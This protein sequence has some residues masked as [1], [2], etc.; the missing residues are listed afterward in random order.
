MND[1]R[2]AAATVAAALTASSTNN[3]PRYTL[4]RRGVPRAA[5]KNSARPDCWLQRH[6]APVRM[7]HDTAGTEPAAER[8]LDAWAQRCHPRAHANDS[9]QHVDT[10]RTA[11]A[12]TPHRAAKPESLVDNAALAFYWHSFTSQLPQA[13]SA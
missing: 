13:S 4:G 3:T 12:R 8:V 11:T 9:H 2:R 6:C 7:V 1:L 10:T 5:R